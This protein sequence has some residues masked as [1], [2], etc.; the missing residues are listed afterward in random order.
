MGDLLLDAVRN[1][2]ELSSRGGPHASGWP[3]RCLV[4]R[5]RVGLRG[6]EHACPRPRLRLVVPRAVAA[7][8]RGS[9]VVRVG[10]VP[11]FGGFFVSVLR[12][13]AGFRLRSICLRL[14]LV[15][16]AFPFLP[17]TWLLAVTLREGHGR[18]EEDR[19]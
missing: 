11:V 8:G 12:R 1:R 6:P 14:V 7:F 18:N 17:M 2:F 13:A 9:M 4:G 19:R 16:G 3:G 10:R 15:G 5:V